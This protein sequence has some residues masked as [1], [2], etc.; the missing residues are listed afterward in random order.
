MEKAE[1]YTKPSPETEGP[2]PVD[3]ATPTIAE[4]YYEQGEIDAAIA[5]YERV[6]AD[7]PEHPDAARRLAEL[8]GTSQEEKTAIDTESPP[9]DM[10]KILMD[11]LKRWLPKIRDINHAHP[12]P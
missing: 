1:G 5:T 11:I 12:T 7:N 8:R 2:A 10:N 6:L 4:L 3:F 9:D